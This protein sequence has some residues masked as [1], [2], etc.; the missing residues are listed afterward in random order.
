MQSQSSFSLL[1]CQTTYYTTHFF[2]DDDIT[3]YS[4]LLY[5]SVFF[6]IHSKYVCV[7]IRYVS[8]G[9]RHWNTLGSLTLSFIPSIWYFVAKNSY[10]WLT[11][12]VWCDDDDDLVITKYK[13]HYTKQFN[14][15]M[16]NMTIRIIGLVFS[17]TFF[18]SHIFFFWSVHIHTCDVTKKYMWGRRSKLNLVHL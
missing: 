10:D 17:T 18:L 6:G 3:T 16:T 5:Q 9:K 15:S 8:Y 2:L 1:S 12:G 11:A 14:S 4:H 13:Q 7:S